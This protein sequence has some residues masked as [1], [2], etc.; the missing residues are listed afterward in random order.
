MECLAYPSWLGGAM[1]ALVFA[2]SSALFLAVAHYGYTHEMRAKNDWSLANWRTV[3]LVLLMGVGSLAM[4][5]KL[6]WL[7]YI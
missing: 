4:N 7:T 6:L 2:M 5:V 1:G 3:I